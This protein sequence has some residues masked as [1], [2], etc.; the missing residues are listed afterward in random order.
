M[1]VDDTVISRRKCPFTLDWT[2]TQRRNVV[3]SPLRSAQSL[4]GNNNVTVLIHVHNTTGD[5]I[6][7][8]NKYLNASCTNVYIYTS[9]RHYAML[10]CCVP[11]NCAVGREILVAKRESPGKARIGMP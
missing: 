4:G 9:Q 6:Y 11:M 3:V 1:A 7:F 5:Y 2:Y 10:R 8:A